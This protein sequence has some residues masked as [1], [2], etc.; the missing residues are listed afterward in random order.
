[1]SK[2]H[3]QDNPSLPHKAF[4]DV[5]AK[6]Y[7][8]EQQQVKSRITLMLVEAWDD[9][10]REGRMI[11]DKTGTA[12]ELKGQLS[13]ALL[14]ALDGTLDLDALS[15]GYCRQVR[16]EPSRRDKSAVMRRQGRCAHAR[17]ARLASARA[18][19]S[20][21]ARARASESRGL[22]PSPTRQSVP[23]PCARAR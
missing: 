13:E 18:R 14:Q 19:Q 22:R 8:R 4:R 7:Q 21:S 15:C 17:P 12:A 16:I 2:K 23:A 20:I 3:C 1:M 6:R 11:A 9:F 10:K 5:V